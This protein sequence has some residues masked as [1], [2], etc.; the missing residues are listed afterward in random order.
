M[1]ELKVYVVTE[2][3][4]NGWSYEDREYYYD[5]FLTICGS[6]KEARGYIENLVLD[7]YYNA[8]EEAEEEFGD[9]LNSEAPN[10]DIFSFDVIEHDFDYMEVQ[11][12]R[13]GGCEYYTYKILEETIQIP[14]NV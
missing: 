10:R 9:L 12:R 13:D 8:I 1:K 7:L 14:D 5:R 3:Y 6:A 2:T 4:D 11:N